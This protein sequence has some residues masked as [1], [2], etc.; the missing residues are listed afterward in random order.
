MIVIDYKTTGVWTY[1]LNADGLKPEW[2]CQTNSYRYLLTK[3]K[4]IEV[5][6]LYILVI[7]RD[8]RAS[9]AK[10]RNDY[11]AAP[12]LQLPVPLWSWEETEAYVEE[13]LALHQDAA[14]SALVGSRLPD[15]TP[16]EMWSQPDRYAVLKSA[17]A[18]R[19]SKVCNSIDE[20][21]TWA[22]DNQMNG[23]HVIEHRPGKRTRCEDWCKVA[24]W[25]DQYQE[26]LGNKDV[27]V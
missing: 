18:K 23:D 25:C 21:I 19:A 14:Y 26:Y 8:W 24:Q 4:G 2:I 7:F 10:K 3:A 13:R 15:C 20:A 17:T 1:M 16:E 11:P 5:S 22:S 12:V 27:S 9:D 6:A